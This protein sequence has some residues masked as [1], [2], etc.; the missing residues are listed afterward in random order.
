MRRAADA[1]TQVHSQDD[2]TA[3]AWI[4]GTPDYAEITLDGG[5]DVD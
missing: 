3:I 5:G 1:W 4:L 2:V